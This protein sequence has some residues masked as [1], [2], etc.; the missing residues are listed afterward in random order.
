M[1]SLAAATVCI[2]MG[3]IAS[4]FATAQ[5]S[6]TAS[7][8]VVAEATG[9]APV[10]VPPIILDECLLACIADFNDQADEADEERD[11][12]YQTAEQ[13]Y[14]D[15]V[16]QVLENTRNICMNGTEEECLAAQAGEAFAINLALQDYL[17]A[18]DDADAA[19]ELAMMLAQEAFDD[20][21]AA[22]DDDPA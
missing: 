17:F 22:C 8:A 6:Q 7:N 14:R 21:I 5:S 15:A 3:M 20:C 4:L 9:F 10:P 16:N 19:H 11:E 18:R 13:D 2:L 1:K 12:A